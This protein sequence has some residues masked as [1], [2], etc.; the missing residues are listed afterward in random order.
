MRIHSS[1]RDDCYVDYYVFSYVNNSTSYPVYISLRQKDFMWEIIKKI[2]CCILPEI[3]HAFAAHQ[4]DVA[5]QLLHMPPVPVEFIWEEAESEQKI[6]QVFLTEIKKWK[7]DIAF[8]LNWVKN[9]KMLLSAIHDDPELFFDEKIIPVLAE[10]LRKK[11]Y[12]C[13]IAIVG[14]LDERSDRILCRVFDSPF[15]EFQ[16]IGADADT[17]T[18]AKWQL[19]FTKIIDRFLSV[20]IIDLLP[21]GN[22]GYDAYNRRRMVGYEYLSISRMDS[23]RNFPQASQCLIRSIANYAKTSGD[24]STLILTLKQWRVFYF[25]LLD[26]FAPALYSKAVTRGGIKQIFDLCLDADM[27]YLL[28]AI[29]LDKHAEEI[30]SEY[31]ASAQA[32]APITKEAGKLLESRTNR[33][34][35]WDVEVDSMLEK[36]FSFLQKLIKNGKVLSAIHVLH[37]YFFGILSYYYDPTAKHGI[38]RLC[39]FYIKCFTE[40]KQYEVLR[41]YYPHVEAL[42]ENLEF[43]ESMIPH[44]LEINEPESA[45][46]ALQKMTQLEPSYPFLATAARDIERCRLV[47]SLASQNIDLQS[48]DSLSGQEFEALIIR[49]FREMGFDAQPTPS[50]GDFGADILVENKEQTRFVIQCKRFRAKVNLK[51]VQEVVA[52]LAHFNG[53]IGIVITNN[54]FLS[55]AVKLAE[56]NDIELWDSMKLMRFLAGDLSFSAIGECSE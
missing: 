19:T 14:M 41:K 28:L 42:N 54:T 9:K 45:A 5:C 31:P 3:E 34:V 48:L 2:V 55:S 40:L 51:A 16:H 1:T 49:K 20:K 7:E 52:A 29:L 18:I 8:A 27:Q 37:A 35:P 43:L 13:I 6:E 46:E 24:F 32:Y 47:K 33:S 53:D 23:K 11:S 17:A 21:G 39:D 56:S 44:F 12:R 10:A 36:F 15:F 38:K 4:L 22:Y 50:S 25:P 26:N 30:L